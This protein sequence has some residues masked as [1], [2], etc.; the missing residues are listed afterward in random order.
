[1]LRI[2]S[3][4]AVLTLAATTGF[5]AAQGATGPRDPNMPDPKNVPAEKVAPPERAITGSTT[6][7]TLSDKLE[8]TEGVITPPATGAVDMRVPAPAPNPGTTRVITP[9]GTSPSDPIQPK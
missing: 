3:G 9:P 6:G 5:A 7:Q 4:L 8:R 2:R 1:M